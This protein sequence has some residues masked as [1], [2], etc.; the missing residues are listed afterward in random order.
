MKKMSLEEI[1]D[2][3]AGMENKIEKRE[4]W[5][6]K[7]KKNDENWSKLNNMGVGKWVLLCNNTKL[8]A[9]MAIENALLQLNLISKQQ[10]GHASDLTKD[11]LRQIAMIM[12]VKEHNQKIS[13]ENLILKILEHAR[14]EK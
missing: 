2:M 9:C 5:F 11:S 13:K 6:E 8:K 10:Q 7:L 4:E 12:G 3:L 1:Q 14:A